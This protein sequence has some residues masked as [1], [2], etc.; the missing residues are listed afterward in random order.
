MWNTEVQ[1]CVHRISWLIWKYD[2]IL[3][4]IIACFR[5]SSMLQ[6]SS[7]PSLQSDCKLKNFL[8]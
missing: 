2:I 3:L 4:G 5:M 1:Y 6:L 8:F 7:G